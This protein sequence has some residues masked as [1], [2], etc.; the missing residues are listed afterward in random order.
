MNNCDFDL[1]TIGGGLGGSSLAK[2]MA[3]NGARV[4]VVERERRFSDRIRGEWIAPWGVT[5]AQRIGIGDALL[6]SA[7][8]LPIFEFVG[9]GPARDLTITTP[10]RTPALTLYHPSMQE[11]LLEAA[12]GS[13]AEI[14]RGATVRGI[15][16]GTRTVLVEHD[17][18]AE[19]IKPRLIVCADGRSSAGRQWV[20]FAVR[21]EKQKLL[22]A[23]LLFEN[24]ATS[25]DAAKSF[26]NPKLRRV[27]YLFPQP[28]ARTRAYL[29]Y[30]PS[31]IGRLQ[32]AGDISRF[33]SE[34]VTTGVPAETFASAKAIGPLASFDMTENWVEHPYRDGV[35]LIGDAAG[36]SDPTWGQ[37]LSI[38]M[39]DVREL[40]E[41]LLTCDD[42]QLACD[43]YARARGTYFQTELRVSGWL[44]SL[45][46]DE[47]PQAD[48]IRERALPLLAAEPDRVPDHGFSGLDLPCDEQVRRRFFG[49]A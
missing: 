39:R 7:R 6:K 32:G 35:V 20:G 28:N 43:R 3:A 24:A 29:M 42:W 36:S 4:L 19:E 16:P 13:G 37:G 27:A 14:W 21:R 15:R 49:D 47:G 25:G 1:L 23:G 2:K 10:Q 46:F 17:G 26:L 8:E 11:A 30:D 5:E 34:S 22:G 18:R 45:F 44:F 38:T 40:C 41:N 31:R 9:L 33:I 12:R 48:R